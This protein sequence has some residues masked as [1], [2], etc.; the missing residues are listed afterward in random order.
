M[1]EIKYH[2]DVLLYLDEL[3]DILIDEGYFSFYENS[4]RYIEDLVN[5]IKRNIIRYITNN[6][7]A[8]QYFV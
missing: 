1:T 4:A 7:V 8:A 6:H 2:K 5:Y 3:T